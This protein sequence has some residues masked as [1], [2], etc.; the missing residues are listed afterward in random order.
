MYKEIIT[1]LV[2]TAPIFE[3][4]GAIPLGVSFGLSP[5]E[6]YFFGTLGTTIMIFPLLVFWRYGENFLAKHSIT[7]KR[8]FD[9]VFEKTRV[10]HGARF[11]TFN[12]LALMLFVAIPL[13]FTGMWSATI[14]SFLFDINVKK[15]FF[16][17]LL[18]VLI[19]SFLVLGATM[20]VISIF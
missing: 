10:R 5:W 14:I 9:W 15:A 4:R 8:F 3:L 18:G 1:F 11:E 12:F 20:G 2:G 7:A 13:P 16:A 17:I 19:A 6:A